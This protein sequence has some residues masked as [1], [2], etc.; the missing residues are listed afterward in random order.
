MEHVTRRVALLGAPN[1]ALAAPF[2][3][4][5]SAETRWQWAKAYPNGDF[6]T[7]NLRDCTMQVRGA[8]GRPPNQM[9]PDAALRKMSEIQRGMQT[10][11]A[12]GLFPPGFFSEGGG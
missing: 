11:Q 9:H 4:K 2:I 6:L 10:G 7:R 3:S 1:L 12:H 5:A 8:A